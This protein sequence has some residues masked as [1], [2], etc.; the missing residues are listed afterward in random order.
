MNLI[1][2][3]C[4]HHLFTS[5]A[6]A[7]TLALS[8]CG[9]GGTS[10]GDNTALSAVPTGGDITCGMINFQAEMLG[11]VNNARAA[12][13]VC[14]GV[15]FPPAAAVRWDTQLQ[16]AATAH[17]EDM[18]SHNFFAH[19]SPTNGSTLRERVPAAGYKYSS[20]GENLGAGQT[21]IS[22][23][24]AEWLASPSHC[25]TMMKANFVDMGVSCKSNPGTAYGTYW[26]MELGVR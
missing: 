20:V 6:L 10:S 13:A 7:F 22:Q 15:A 2:N 12:G 25:A 23:V 14:G 18:A 1:H 24:V 19:Q 3:F 4:H 17:S 21:S 5:I 11:T 16:N 8:A 9:G 26:T